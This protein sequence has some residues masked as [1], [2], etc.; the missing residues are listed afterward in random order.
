MSVGSLKVLDHFIG[1][2]ASIAQTQRAKGFVWRKS[3]GLA[4]AE[5]VAGKEGAPCSR[6]GV[7]NFSHGGFWCNGHGGD[8]RR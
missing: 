8:R 7:E 1:I 4:T 6:Q 2:Y 5:M 3:T